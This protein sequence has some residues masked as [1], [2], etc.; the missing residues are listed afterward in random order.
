MNIETVWS[1]VNQ[2]KDVKSPEVELKKLL[3]SFSVEDVKRF[4]HHFDSLHYYGDRDDIDC[5]AHLLNCY[6]DVPESIAFVSGIIAKGR[7][8]Y[9]SVL[10]NADHLHLFWNKG[11]IKNKAFGW[12]AHDVYAENLAISEQEARHILLESTPHH[13][14]SLYCYVNGELYESQEPENWDF[15]NEQDNRKRLPR[16]SKLYYGH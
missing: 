9:E 1:L 16:L 5:A 2:C 12:V 15:Y 3:S 10:R 4:A 7:E 6:C 8:T 11:K 14:F 13:D